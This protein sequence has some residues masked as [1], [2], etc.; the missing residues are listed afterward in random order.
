VFEV[1]ETA[2]REVERMLEQMD[3]LMAG[4]PERLHEE[5]GSL[6]ELDGMAPSD[7][8]FMPLM[9][10]FSHPARAHIS[11]EEQQVW[12]G[13]RAA[14]PA[15]EA[16][17]LGGKLDAAAMAGPTRPHPHTPANPAVL[18]AAGPV[19]AAADRLRDAASGRDN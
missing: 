11:H 1:L 9:T 7:Q 2:H 10:K 18:K 15:D 19:V 17:E 12:P 16:I 6:A 8:Q 4:P 13:V 5:G 14:L 3:A